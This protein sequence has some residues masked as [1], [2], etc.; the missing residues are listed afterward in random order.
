MDNLTL[1]PKF[2]LARADE[3]AKH[4]R[5]YDVPTDCRACR[6]DG[7][8]ADDDVVGTSEKCYACKGTGEGHLE[9]S[10]CIDEDEQS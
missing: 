6:G 4:K 10:A 7:W 2:Y 8:I 1:N 3:C 9:C 5:Y